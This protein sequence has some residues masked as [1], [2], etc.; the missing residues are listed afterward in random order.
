MNGKRPAIVIAGTSSN[1]GKTT[2]SLGLMA[3]MTAAGNH[4]QPF[5]CGPDFIDPTLHRKVTGRTSWNLDLRICSRE[6]VTALFEAVSVENGINIVEGVMGLFDGGD[7]SAAAIARLLDLPVL[8]VVD[9]ASAAESIAAVIKGFEVMDPAVHIAGVVLNRIASKRHLEL[10]SDA[11]RRHCQAEIA[12][13][14]PRDLNI[15]IPSRHL[16]LHMGEELSG[17][18]LQRLS[19]LAQKHL[20]LKMVEKI[21][22][23][24]VSRLI[25]TPI[26]PPWLDQDEEG[27]GSPDP[28]TR[29]GV[30][31]DRAF[32]FYYQDN[33]EM[34]R[35]AGAELVEFS[36]VNDEHLP[37]D[38][39][40]LYIGGGYPELY[41]AE[42]QENRSMRHAILQ[43]SRSGRPVFAECGGFMYLCDSIETIDGKRFQMA[44]IFSAVSSME[45][46]LSA[47]GYR[48]VVTILDTP[49]APRHTLMKGH[50]FHYSRTNFPQEPEK[51]FQF[52]NGR[53]EGYLCNNTLAGYCHLHFGSNPEIASNFA[54]ACCRRA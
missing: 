6:Y 42:L 24:A 16:G 50:E 44:G 51:A 9:T 45:K 52:Q 47:L 10:V 40:G 23:R 38:L 4:I 17:E 11:V 30:A 39:D 34:L 15:S 21:A 25:K 12:G 36:P 26:T 7:S 28:R 46:R 20:D 14:L 29:I 54:K 53:K 31:M 35:S 3:A 32:C 18:W 43:F 49:I 22:S 13:F 2:V 48:E 41:G 8:L 5:K 33:L 27:Q 19:Q 37:A 1:C